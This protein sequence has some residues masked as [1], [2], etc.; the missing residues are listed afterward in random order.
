NAQATNA[1]YYSISVNHAS[2]TNLVAY[3]G[4][5]QGPPPPVANADIFTVRQNSSYNQ[6][7]VLAND[8][9]TVGSLTI[10][11]YTEPTHGTVST[12]GQYL[13]YDSTVQPDY[14]GPD[15]FTYTVADGIGATST[16]TVTVFVSPTD[17]DNLQANDISVI[18]QTNV[19][20]AVIDLTTND[21]SCS[22]TNITNIS[23]Y[24]PGTPSLGTVS[25]SGT[26]ITYTRN[27]NLFGTDIFTYTIT[28]T[29]GDWA[30]ANITI[31]QTNAAGDGMPDQWKLLYGLS[32]TQDV[33]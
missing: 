27:T 3:F 11:N 20:T 1:G 9:V 19:F 2:P 10:T 32:L 24:S 15:S 26:A 16:T 25:V 30:Q 23:V 22:I 29:N 21:W 33:S 28:D 5:L 18:L 8:S 6:L 7:D 12:D 17:S 14:I 4:V 31:S 13:Y